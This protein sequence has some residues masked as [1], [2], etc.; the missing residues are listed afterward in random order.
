MRKKKITQKFQKN[1]S[2][3]SSFHKGRFPSHLSTLILLI[4]AKNE[5]S[6]LQ[7]IFLLLFIAVRNCFEYSLFWKTNTF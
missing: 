2:N 7:N 4:L 1:A 5:E 6:Y 3:K